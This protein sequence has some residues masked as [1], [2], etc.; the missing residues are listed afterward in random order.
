M[1]LNEH[2]D[3]RAA[4]AA[5]IMYAAWV[6]RS[7]MHDVNPV[8]THYLRVKRIKSLPVNEGHTLIPGP[9]DDVRAIC[10]PLH[11]GHP[12]DGEEACSPGFLLELA[13]VNVDVVGHPGTQA[14]CHFTDALVQR[15][16][17]DATEVST[18]GLEGPGGVEAEDC[19]DIHGHRERVSSCQIRC[20]TVSL[21]KHSLQWHMVSCSQ[22]KD[23][24]I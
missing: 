17:G 9:Q 1:V 23:L 19:P 21:L 11:E 10:S 18:G 5:A 13:H 15:E 3:V 12:G 6:A 4:G 7:H 20:R 2:G 22:L 14:I 8:V 24:R 16:L